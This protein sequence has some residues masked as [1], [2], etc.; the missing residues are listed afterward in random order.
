MTISFII[1]ER[2][3]DTLFNNEFSQKWFDYTIVRPELADDLKEN[4]PHTYP[5]IGRDFVSV[6][7]NP[8]PNN[9]TIMG[10]GAGICIGSNYHFTN[11]TG[12]LGG[13]WTSSNTGIG[14]I[15]AG[16]GDFASLSVGT[17]TIHYSVTNSCGTTTPASFVLAVNPLPTTPTITGNAPM[18]EA[19]IMTTLNGS[20]GGG[21]WTSSNP[22]VGTVD[23]STG[24]VTGISAGN[25]N[26]TYTL[27]TIYG[28]QAYSFVVVTV[29]P[30]PASITGTLGICNGSTTTLSDATGSGSWS[31]VSTGVATIDASTGVV[32]SVSVGTSTI[33]YTLATGCLAF[34][35]V[36]VNV[37]PTGGT[38]SGTN[39]IDIY[40]S[41]YT[42]SLTVTGA[43]GGGSWSSSNSVAGTVDGSGVVTGLGPGYT[44]ITYSVTVGACSA[45]STY[46]VLVNT[47]GSLTGA[48]SVCAPTA[49]GPYNPGTNT[50]L[51]CSAVADVWTSSTGTV[52]I[53]P[54]YAYTADVYGVL[55][56]T[57]IISACNSGTGA[58]SYFVMTI[59]PD[60]IVG[61][62]NSGPGDVYPGTPFQYTLTTGSTYS[63]Y[64]TW[65]SGVT[66]YADFTGSPGLLI[67]QTY[68][69]CSGNVFFIYTDAHGCQGYSGMESATVH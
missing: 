23:A 40:A 19:D 56:G 2:Q 46:L 64:G 52:S 18:C 36:T 39:T 15:D 4:K 14:T 30:L 65:V 31:S 49:S 35:E 7:V 62:I 8:L 3:I 9:G 69:P 32:T 10:P 45:S 38:I 20:S 57:S 12:D 67:Y 16:T 42:T 68:G 47:L 48:T 13:T 58:C 53:F 27:A 43:T 21:T 5:C 25:T 26:I 41:T 50:T 29:N 55:A 61:T 11:P 44:V 54:D 17:T 60:P 22:S 24:Y 1:E 66:P 28:C 37:M 6:T 63:P 51:T 59:Y 33:N 34:T